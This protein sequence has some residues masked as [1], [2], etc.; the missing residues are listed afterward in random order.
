MPQFDL[1]KTL[2]GKSFV[3][4]IFFGKNFFGKL[5]AADIYLT[6]CKF[7]MLTFLLIL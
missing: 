7:E 1:A 5:I 2:E 6:A 3:D 4:G